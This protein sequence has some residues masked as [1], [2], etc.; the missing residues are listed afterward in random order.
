MAAGFFTGTEKYMNEETPLVD[1]RFLIQKFPG[2]GGWSY[3][4][5]FAKALAKSFFL[6][7]CVRFCYF[8]S[9]TQP[10]LRFLRVG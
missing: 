5:R 3:M 7:K 6:E 8:M 4:D 2:K 1:K 9:D 10:T